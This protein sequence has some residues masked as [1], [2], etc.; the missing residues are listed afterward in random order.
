MKIG[1]F[2]SGIGGLAVAR[3]LG[4]LLPDAEIISVNDHAHVPYGTRPMNEIINLTTAA[5]RPLIDQKCDAIV[6]ACN[7]ATT[8]AITD[9]R[10]TYPAMN[11][12]GIEP[13][14]KPATLTTTSNVIAV[15]ATPA[16]LKSK[17]YA[18]LKGRW[19]DGIA[20]IE[21]DCSTWATAIEAGSSDDVPIEDTVHSLV[22]QGVDVIVLA[23]TH[24]HW[25]KDRAEL[26]AAGK[27]VILE[28]TDA[29]SSRLLSLISKS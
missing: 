29:I 3:R 2:D 20:I 22:D 5:V 14:V 21:P 24:Y 28:P 10:A 19:A 18:T 8:I 26:A 12:V 4:E 11:F 27:A 15:L 1:V 25:L 16:T 9:L 23:C 6:I 7:T 17:P 13:M